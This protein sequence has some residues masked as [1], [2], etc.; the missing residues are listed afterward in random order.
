MFK[1]LCPM[2]LWM[3]D[4]ADNYCKG[5]STSHRPEQ[6][7]CGPR[8]EHCCIDCFYCLSPIAFVFDIICIPFTVYYNCS[9]K[10]NEAAAI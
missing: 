7:C 3:C 4:E 2:S 10:E 9:V 5:S 1:E 6:N 8:G